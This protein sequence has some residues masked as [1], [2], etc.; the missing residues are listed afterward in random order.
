MMFE[1]VAMFGKNV[2]HNYTPLQKRYYV[3]F[4]MHYMY[5]YLSQICRYKLGRSHTNISPHVKPLPSWTLWWKGASF[6]ASCCCAC[7]VFWTQSNCVCV[8]YAVIWQCICVFH[9]WSSF[10][11]YQN[12]KTENH[13]ICHHGGSRWR[14]SMESPFYICDFCRSFEFV[15]FQW[16]WHYS[17]Y[18][19]YQLEFYAYIGLTVPILSYLLNFKRCI[20]TNLSQ[21]W[22]YM[23]DKSYWM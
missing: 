23:F 18:I 4:S 5:M 14:R 22:K 12:N 10:D 9:L 6:R 2:H 3:W 13:Q 1:F 19:Q 15:Q 17:Q 21:I 7:V 11:S 20:H 16:A 8:F